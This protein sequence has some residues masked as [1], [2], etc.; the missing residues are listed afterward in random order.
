MIIA[1]NG[2]YETC[3]DCGKLVKINKWCGGLH[4]CIS[5]EQRAAKRHYQ[6]MMQQQM[7]YRPQL[8]GLGEGLGASVFKQQP[9]NKSDD[10]ND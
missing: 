7:N 5:K 2:I 3:G 4:F 8:M 10:F 9:S 1:G 6:H